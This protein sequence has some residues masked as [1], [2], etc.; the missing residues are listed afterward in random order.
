MAGRPS[1]KE[2]CVFRNEVPN[3]STIRSNETVPSSVPEI[4]EEASQMM[5]IAGWLGKKRGWKTSQFSRDYKL[6]H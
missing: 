4:P 3:E 6:T 1:F 5:K 2:A